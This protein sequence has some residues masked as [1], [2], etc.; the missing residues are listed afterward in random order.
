MASQADQQ[1]THLQI[2]PEEYDYVYDDSIDSALRASN[3][4]PMKADYVEFHNRKRQLFQLPNYCPKG[5]TWSETKSWSSNNLEIF[6]AAALENIIDSIE[7]LSYQDLEIAYNKM[8]SGYGHRKKSKLENE[9]DKLCSECGFVEGYKLLYCPWK[10]LEESKTVF[11]SLN[12]GRVPDEFEKK[13]ISEERGNSYSIELKQSVSPLNEQF[14]KLFQLIDTPIEQVLTGAYVPFRSNRWSDLNELQKLS[15]LQFASN[16]WTPVVLRSEL[17]V[18]CGRLVFQEV[19]KSVEPFI[20]S[21]QSYPSGWGK[22][23]LQ[24]ITLDTGVRI[25]G[26]PHLSSYRL[27]NNDN[28]RASLS[29]LFSQI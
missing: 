23:L 1:S 7:K 26:T 25:L 28:S 14:I 8:L 24:V 5:K 16:F 11:L 2:F 12:P 22:T 15:A 4:N 19:A 9:L 6:G 29:R 18:C 3:T 27:L 10:L 13:A 17:V 21:S 20:H